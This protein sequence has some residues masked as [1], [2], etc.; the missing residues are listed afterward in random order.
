MFQEPLLALRPS[1]VPYM[2]EAA[3]A[4][5][6]N[7]AASGANGARDVPSVPSWVM[8]SV[9]EEAGRALDIIGCTSTRM[10]PQRSYDV[11]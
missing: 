10:A 4:R 5:G 8:L 6:E 3:N 11:S 9:H 7:S 2:N 1:G